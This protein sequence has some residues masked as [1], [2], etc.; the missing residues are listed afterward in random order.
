MKLL[1]VSFILLS[2]ATTTSVAEALNPFHSDG[3]SL[4]PDGTADQ[5]QLWLSCCQQH[6]YEY[7]KGGSYEERLQSDQKLEECVA[8]AGEP[9]I[10]L[11]MLAGVRVGGSPLLPTKF[12]WGY[13]WPYPK[14]YGK[15]TEEELEQVKELSPPHFKKQ[16]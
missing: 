10:A 1:L 9:E 5:S 2:A 8:T 16:Q 7:W 13:G 12:R 15:L 14:A 6:D 3:C 4:F 11:L